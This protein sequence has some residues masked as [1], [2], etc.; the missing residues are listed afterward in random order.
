VC[1]KRTRAC[2]RY[3]NRHSGKLIW[4]VIGA[5]S[6]WI[7]LIALIEGGDDGGFQNSEDTPWG[8]VELML[9]DAGRGACVCVCVC[10]LCTEGRRTAP[11]AK[12]SYRQQCIHDGTAAAV[13]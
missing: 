4:V 6:A 3:Y 5:F 9:K 11:V 2:R 1:R 10:T 12:T 13:A 8:M 7:M